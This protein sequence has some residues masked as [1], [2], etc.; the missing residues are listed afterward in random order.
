MIAVV[1]NLVS[2]FFSRAV[3][4]AAIGETLAISGTPGMKQHNKDTSTAA[5]VRYKWN[6][7]GF[8]QQQG[9]QLVVNK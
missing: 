7:R 5:L 2:I 8:Q 4:K 3:G 6:R 9:S 1:Q